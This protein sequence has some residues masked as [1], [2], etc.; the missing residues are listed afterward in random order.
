MVYKIFLDTNIFLDHLLDRNSYSSDILKSCEES[1]LDGYVSSASFYTLAYVIR[2]HLSAAETRKLLGNYL[3]FLS[4]L[5]TQKNTLRNSLDAS[6]HDLEDAFQYFTALQED[7]LDFFITNNLKDF[8]KVSQQLPVINSKK[9]VEQYL[10][11]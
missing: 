5:P 9:F 1:I 10:S 8:K 6:F 11:E 7:K 4:I 2:K 3:R